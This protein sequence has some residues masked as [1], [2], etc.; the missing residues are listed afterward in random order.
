MIAGSGVVIRVP[1]AWPTAL[2]YR[3]WV[4]EVWVNYLSNAIKYGRIPPAT[5][6]IELGF[7]ESSDRFIRFWVRD[8][9]PG[10]PPEEQ[11]DLFKA[12]G[13]HS[14]VRA[15]GH[16]LGLSIVR[17][18]VEKMGGQVGVESTVGQGSTF[19]FTLRTLD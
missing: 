11:V 5:P 3:Q 6:R 15:T 8:S 10:I 14:K 1:G 17:M 13:E 18:I 2:G 7:D 12:Y 4:E 9:G 19:Y 16:G